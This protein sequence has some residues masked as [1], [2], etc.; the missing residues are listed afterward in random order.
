MLAGVRILHAW[1]DDLSKSPNDEPRLRAR[2]INMVDLGGQQEKGLSVK[3]EVAKDYFL[4]VCQGQDPNQTFPS[5]PRGF[6]GP[7]NCALEIWSV[8]AVFG[9]A[10]R[11]L[12]LAE[13][14]LK[15]SPRWTTRRPR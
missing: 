13:R 12:A 10:A 4:D 11:N 5:L 9:T 2:G 3:L 14:N 6:L 8:G 7:G 15:Y 1:C